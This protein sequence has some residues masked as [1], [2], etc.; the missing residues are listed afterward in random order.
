MAAPAL[1]CYLWLSPLL[2]HLGAVPGSLQGHQPSAADREEP[3]S[4]L[5]PS[6]PG[7][8]W[9]PGRHTHVRVPT[10]ALL[11]RTAAAAHSERD[12]NRC[13]RGAMTVTQVVQRALG[14]LLSNNFDATNLLLF[15]DLLMCQLLKKKKLHW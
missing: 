1:P 4:S 15:K 11:L 3:W 5:H 2:A 14:L 13:F 6:V 7:Y 8:S 12:S 9:V 10:E